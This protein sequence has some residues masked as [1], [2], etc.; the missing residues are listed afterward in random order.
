LGRAYKPYF[1]CIFGFPPYLIYNASSSDK[2]ASDLEQMENE[3]QATGEKLK[4]Q[5]TQREEGMHFMFT[6]NLLHS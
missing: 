1:S 5:M 6:E 2:T 4:S 3:E